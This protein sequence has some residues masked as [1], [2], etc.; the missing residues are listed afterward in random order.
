MEDVYLIEGARTAFT[1]FTG[2]FATVSAIQLGTVTAVEALN[3]SKVAPEDVDAVFYGNVIATGKDAAYTARHIALLAGLPEEIP[4]LTLNRLCGSGL[5]SVISG[6]QEI[7]LGESQ[8]VLAGGTEN[9]SQAPFSN[10]E[11]RSQSSKMGNIQ[12]EDMLQA[13]LTDQYT[14]MGMGMTAENLAE[15]YAITRE[16][17]DAYAVLSHERAAASQQ[18]DVFAREIV[19]VQV[20]TRKGTRVIE[21]DEQIRPDTTVEQM[22]QLQPVFKRQGTVTAA[23]ASSI[24]DGAASIVLASGQAVEEKGL[25]PLAKIISYAAVGVDP[26]YMGI[27]PVPAI[28]RALVRANLTIDDIDL[29]EIN[30]AF[31]AQYLAVE[32]EL[33][34]DRN[35]VNVHGGAIALGHPVGASGTRVLLSAAHTLHERQERYAVVSLC[36]GG[37]QGIAMIIERV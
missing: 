3:R 32:Q 17:Q 14:G 27:G 11:Q 2:S 24:N 18:A 35:R 13:T 30:E 10:F 4:A 31:A 37:G 5:Q 6:A 16:Q 26:N 22:A 9:M 12:F 8:I 1:A 23:N 29:F 36:I 21:Q 28:K 25:Q 15:K 34:L 19:P 7:Q 20:P 33:Q